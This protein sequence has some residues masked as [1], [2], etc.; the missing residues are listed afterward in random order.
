MIEN[1][2]EVDQDV[3]EQIYKEFS[4]QDGRFKMVTDSDG[5]KYYILTKF[6]VYSDIA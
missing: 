4:N 5:T 1:Y 6:L 3:F 2:T